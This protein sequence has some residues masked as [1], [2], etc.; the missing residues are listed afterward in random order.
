MQANNIEMFKTQPCA[1]NFEQKRKFQ[2]WFPCIL[3]TS[4]NHLENIFLK[5]QDIFKHI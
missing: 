1:W 2:Y 5:P 4:Y 3:F